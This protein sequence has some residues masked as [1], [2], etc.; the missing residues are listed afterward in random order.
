[1]LGQNLC[2]LFTFP[3]AMRNGFFLGADRRV[4]FQ[5]VDWQRIKVEGTL[6]GR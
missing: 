5:L 1:M 4:R 2:V 6:G 3:V